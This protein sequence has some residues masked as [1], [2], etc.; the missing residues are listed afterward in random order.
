L[1]DEFDIDDEIDTYLR[2]KAQAN[3][4][5]VLGANLSSSGFGF[6]GSQEHV[7]VLT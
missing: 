7:C 2:R 3:W 6:C 4:V 5:Q 1:K